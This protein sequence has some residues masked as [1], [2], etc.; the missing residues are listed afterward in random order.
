[1][2]EWSQHKY[3]V[4]FN[5]YHDNIAS[6]SFQQKLCAELPIDVVYT[7]VN[8]SDPELIQQL[9][10]VKLGMGFN[11]SDQG[12][13]FSEETCNLKNCFMLPLLVLKMQNDSVLQ[14]TE[15]LS[16]FTLHFPRDLISKESLNASVVR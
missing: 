5:L 6:K 9:N 11:A 3:D 8:G 14:D 4:A 10:K 7:W 13:D 1:L 15:I 12:S 16:T 2:L